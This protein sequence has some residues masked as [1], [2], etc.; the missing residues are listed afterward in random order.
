MRHEYDRESQRKIKEAKEKIA[1]LIVNEDKAKE[2]LL[3]QVSA[4]LSTLGQ[5]S[6]C[7]AD[8]YHFDK[9]FIR[10]IKDAIK[11][12]S[13][14]ASHA[15]LIFDIKERRQI[16]SSIRMEAINL[17][18]SKFLDFMNAVVST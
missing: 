1:N 5:L 18:D 8:G 6:E 10:S 12:I 3:L 14:K 11:E 9:A 7:G 13:R 2:K 16:E 15:N 4:G 17:N